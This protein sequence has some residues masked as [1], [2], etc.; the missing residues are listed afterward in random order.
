MNALTTFDWLVLIVGPNLIACISML[1]QRRRHRKYVEAIH[2]LLADEGYVE[3]E[4][5]AYIDETIRMTAALNMPE[6]KAR[7]FAHALLK[8]ESFRKAV[9]HEALYEVYV[10][11]HGRR[12]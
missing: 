3:G 5:A 1:C 7:D 2:A 9:A 11:T 8:Q 10:K 6:P 12:S 4:A